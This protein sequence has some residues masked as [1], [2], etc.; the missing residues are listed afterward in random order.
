MKRF[1][2]LWA[3]LPALFHLHAQDGAVIEGRILDTNEQPVAFATV[4]LHAAADSSV[5]KAAYTTEKGKFFI[6]PLTAGEY[7]LKT[8]FVGLATYS[9][10]IISLGENQKLVLNDILMAEPTGDL[11]EVN[12]VARKPMIEVKPDMT[13]FN[14]A[15]NANSIG[16]NAFDLLRKAPGVIIDNNDNVILMGKSGVRI[17]IDGKPSPLTIADLAAMLKGMQSD[18]IEAIE[19]ITNPSARYDAEGNAGIINIRLKKDQNLGTNGSFSLGYA[20]GRYPK[21]NGSINLNNRNKK[22]N[23]FGNYSGG[24]GRTFSFTNFIR[25]QRGREFNQDSDRFNEFENHNVKAGV[26]FFLN[27]KHTVGV[28]FNGFFSN[29]TGNNVSGTPIVNTL[30]GQPESF[31]DA[32]S[33][34][35]S[36]RMNGNYHINYSFRNKEGMTWNIDLD[37]G[38]YRIDNNTFQ[39]NYFLTPNRAD[40]TAINIFSTIAPTEIDIYTFKAD[41]ERDF[42]GGKLSAGIKSAFIETDND[43]QFSTVEGGENILDEDRSNRFKYEENINAAYA[44][45][46]RK[47]GKWTIEAGLRGEQTQTKGSLVSTMMT[48][49]D[50]VSRDYFNLFP[51]AGITWSPQQKHS[52]RVNYSR[53]ID[54]PRYQDLNPF[55]YQLDELT[56][57]EGNPFL[58]PQYTN[59]YQFTY[60]FNYRYTASIS[61]SRTTD[62]FTQL[63][64]IQS[65]SAS[66]ITLKNLD[67]RDVWSA[68][69]SAPVQVLKWW[70]MY[71]NLNLSRTQNLGDFNAP[72]EEGREVDVSRTTFNLYQQHT[73]NLPKKISLE[74]SGFYSSPSIWG[75][76]YLTEDFWGI[77]VGTQI[78][79]LKEK[80]ILKLSVSDVFN[81]MQWRG[82]QNFGELNFIASGGWES[83]QFKVNLTYNFGNDKVKSSRRRKTGLQDESSRVNSGGNGPGN[84]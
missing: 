47:E 58:L 41:H 1:I 56:F 14:V 35:E 25:T 17:Y 13:V 71:T 2:L 53:R 28:L 4:L 27:E 45:Y 32:I 54:R 39:P 10:E 72:G 70:N 52:Y 77:N 5:A 20:V 24:V 57:Q 29:S 12:I 38:Q 6:G 76:N 36:D 22:M 59:S 37:Y 23:V 67:T 18:Q 84:N 55:R 51:T 60:T 79:L 64:D 31:L 50:T 15:G 3:F 61:Y 65:D 34:N 7:F 48:A 68:N 40:T 78:R 8:Q 49:N 69:I 46:Q 80:A 11:D 30:T 9:S 73:I 16:E 63:T 42:L 83:Q 44:T 81:S 19:I 62:F 33:Q 21:Y 43:F 82:E 74:V 26:D 66:F 75:A